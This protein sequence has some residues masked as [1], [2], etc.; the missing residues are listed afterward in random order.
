MTGV[1]ILSACLLQGSLDHLVPTVTIFGQLARRCNDQPFFRP[2]QSHI[3]QPQPLVAL[4]VL[5]MIASGL[6]HLRH[7]CAGQ[8]PN[9]PALGPHDFLITGRTPFRGVGQDHDGRFQS[10]RSMNRHHADHIARR[11]H[12]PF[13]F[14]IIGL[15]P[16]QKPCEARD[17]TALVGEGL[18]EQ[19]VDAILGFWSQTTEQALATAM[20]G[21]DALDEIIGPQEIGLT[22]Q[23]IQNCHRVGE[24]ICAVSQGFP[25]MAAP[26]SAVGEIEQHLFG[27][28]KQRRF[29]RG[30]QRQGIFWCRKKGQN[31]RQI[32]DRELCPNL[33]TVGTGDRQACS[34]AGA[35][36]LRKQL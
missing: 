14:Q 18:A 16:D 23:I 10:F 5:G 3:Q 21:Q 31:C 25:Q 15:H 12:L 34:L 30:S 29:E 26:V 7:L 22:A 33:Q 36:D 4:F 9:G 13:D 28:A 19:G 35:N 1:V 24:F 8:F 20:T 11:P 27:P 32:L 17:I 2:C 6:H